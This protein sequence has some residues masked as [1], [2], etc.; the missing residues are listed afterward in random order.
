[1]KKINIKMFEFDFDSSYQ[2]TF[3]ITTCSFYFSVIGDRRNFIDD[4]SCLSSFVKLND[5]GFILYRFCL[6]LLN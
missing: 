4:Y 2:K 3:Y 6:V 5:H 1:M